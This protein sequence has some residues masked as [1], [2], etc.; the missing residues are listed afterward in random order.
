M[1]DSTATP[2]LTPRQ[3]AILGLVVGEFIEHA[4]PVGSA[5]LVK[6]YNLGISSATVRNEMKRLE[7]LGYLTHPHT[8]AGRVPTHQGYRYFVQ[9]LLPENSLPETEQHMIRHQFYQV[10]QELEQWVRLAASVLARTTRSA[11][12]STAPRPNQAR[13]KH[14]EL[15]SLQPRTVLM[16]LVL[17]G[18]AV[19]Q[20]LLALDDTWSQEEL[21]RLSQAVNKRLDGLS[22]AEILQREPE[23]DPLERRIVNLIAEILLHRERRQEQI[24]Q[25]GLSNV[26]KSPEF[27]DRG[28]ARRFIELF[29]KPT[30]IV[31]IIQEVRR[32]PGVQVIIGGEEP[33]DEL[34]DVSIVLS[35]YGQPQHAA[36]ILGIVGPIRMPYG[37]T[38]SI[39]RFMSQLMSSMIANLYDDPTLPPPSP[40]DPN[41][42]PPPTFDLT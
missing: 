25:D 5:H 2:T 28:S 7:E 26:L 20:Q 1:Q 22:H 40:P 31:P 8:S 30:T 13:F 11:G 18:G 23:T 34:P 9:N 29:E 10:Q 36:G 14:L 15:I 33:Y 37:R 12:I 41:Q 42:S 27:T 24:Y 4:E 6:T 19:R 32:M 39:V 35:R 38:I 3:Q 16:V 21:S 17:A